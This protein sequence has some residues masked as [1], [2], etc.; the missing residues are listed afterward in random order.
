MLAPPQATLLHEEAVEH[1]E[2][3][4]ES[5]DEE[6]EQPE[7][8]VPPTKEEISLVTKGVELCES[9]VK[10]LADNLDKITLLTTFAEALMKYARVQG[11]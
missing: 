5:D 6:E 7:V 8:V 11:K 1:A 3:Q 9:V 10:T 2:E 4:Q